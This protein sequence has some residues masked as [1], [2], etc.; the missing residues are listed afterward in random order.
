MPSPR[1]PLGR[2]L[3]KLSGEV[4]RGDQPAGL[5]PAVLSRMASELLEAQSAGAEMA[6]VVGGGNIFRGTDGVAVGIDRATG[7]QIGMLST[8]T[9]G[10]ALRAALETA[11]ATVLVQSAIPIPGVVA[12]FDAREAT[13]ALGAG[14]VVIF[15]AGTGNP[16]FTTDTAAALRA[17]QIHADAMVKGTKVDGVYAADPVTHPDAERFTSL[18]YREVLEHQLGVMDLTATALCADQRLPVVVFNLHAPG[19]LA[20]VVRGEAVGTLV[21]AQ[22]E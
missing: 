8:V 7:D 2:V 13:A 14:Q 9:N 17:I 16:Y 21:T 22:A 5:D 18:S 4:L 1:T 15:V 3:L 11:G 20:Q 19:A 10:L 6:L 12:G